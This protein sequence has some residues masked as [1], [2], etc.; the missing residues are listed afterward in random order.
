M[1]AINRQRRQDVLRLETATGGEKGGSP[2]SRERDVAIVEMDI[3]WFHCPDCSFVLTPPVF[4]CKEGHLACDRCRAG[5]CQR[6][7]GGGGTFDTRNKVVEHIISVSKF[8]CPFTGCHR[9]FPFRDLRAHREACLHAPCFCAEPG[10]TFAAPPDT[11]LRHLVVHHL[12]PARPLVYGQVLRLRAPLSEPR[13]LLHAK[14]DGGVFVVVIGA[15][16]A[17]TVVSVVCV[18]KVGGPSQPCYMAELRASGPP[19]PGAATGSI[20]RMPMETVTSTDSPGEV[21]VEKLP[22][23]MSVPSTYLLAGVDGDGAS[24]K[25]HLKIQIKKIS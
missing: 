9:F 15:L 2:S 25:L 1:D 4:Q 6:C 19:L 11:L 20:I 13:R 10:C 22:W 21:S 7:K 3:N 8:K 17:V 5:K 24:K 23:V 12:W 16:G 18:R 14:E